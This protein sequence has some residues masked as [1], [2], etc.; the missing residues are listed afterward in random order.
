MNLV[1]CSATMLLSVQRKVSVQQQ[2]ADGPCA[3]LKQNYQQTPS[4]H[5]MIL[6]DPSSEI[7]S[8]VVSCT[9]L[10]GGSGKICAIP[11]QLSY[12]LITPARNE[13]ALIE[14]TIRSVI[15]QTVL[16]QKWL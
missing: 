15:A 5:P 2:Y 11:P 13:A 1:N 8:G 4:D 3:T 12:V 10:A 6:K 14:L 16:P 9:H 7:D